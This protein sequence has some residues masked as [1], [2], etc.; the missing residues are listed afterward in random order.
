MSVYLCDEVNVCL[1]LFHCGVIT[2]GYMLA[3]LSGKS[4][5]K[6]EDVCS[7]LSGQ[8]QVWSS[9]EMLLFCF[10]AGNDF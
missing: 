5:A 3:N 8:R 9:E 1:C 10:W 2:P 4:S 6:Q 7:K